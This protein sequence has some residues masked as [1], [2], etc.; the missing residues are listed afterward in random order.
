M[1]HPSWLPAHSGHFLRTWPRNSMPRH[2]TFVKH[3]R[4]VGLRSGAAI[5]MS[6]DC[7]GVYRHLRDLHSFWL[8][9]NKTRIRAVLLRLLTAALGICAPSQEGGS[10]SAFGGNAGLA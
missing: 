4:A 7:R 1:G 10:A 2:A 3:C 9:S 5:L 6:T 8:T